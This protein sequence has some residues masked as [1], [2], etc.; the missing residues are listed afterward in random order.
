MRKGRDGEE[1]NRTEQ[2][3]TKENNDGNSGPL[4][5]LPVDLPKVDRLQRRRSCQYDKDLRTSSAHRVQ[6]FWICP[7]FWTFLD[8]H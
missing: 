6:N 8:L 3:R 5:S 7:D 1:Q 2:N 4:T